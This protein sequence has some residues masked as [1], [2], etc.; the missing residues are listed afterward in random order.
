MDFSRIKITGKWFYFFPLL[1]A[2]YPVI[3]LY[4]Q[5]VQELLFPQ[6][7]VPVAVALSATILWWACL[8]FFMKDALKAGVI[9]TV[10]IIFFTM[11]GTL[12][13]WLVSWDL[14]TVKHRHILP[15][16]LFI[17]AYL[18]YFIYR[19]K[20]REL[21]VNAAKVLTILVAVL[22]V[23]NIINI[24][25]YELKKIEYAHQKPLMA[26]TPLS[27]N[28]T[29]VNQSAGYPD[30]YYFVFDEYAS[31]D[32][33]KEIWGYDNSEFENFLK[34][35]G[36]YIAEKSKTRKAES[37]YSMASSLNMEHLDPGT[38]ELS[39]FSQLNNNKVMNSL[40]NKGYTL[41]VFDGIKVF[42]PNK[43]NITA[44]YEYVYNTGMENQNFFINDRSDFENI[45]IEKTMLSSISF[46]FG[47]WN[48]VNDR[49]WNQMTFVFQNMKS[50]QNL[51][52]PK[53][54]YIH[55]NSPHTPFVFDKEGNPVDRKNAHNWRDKRYYLEQLLYTN[56]QITPVIE[57]ILSSE[58]NKPIIIIQ[59]DHGPRPDNSPNRNENFDI[60]LEQKQK[61]FNAYY[62]PGN[63]SGSLYQNISPV[64]SFRVMFNCYFKG[65]FTLLEDD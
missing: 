27:G 42:Y 24:I 30:I 12:F 65:N 56:T 52:S 48:N 33:L 43:G 54:V 25:P 23:L 55:V 40:K 38:D 28:L 49:Y 6:L 10:F 63:C 35:K 19:I 15:I 16:V 39:L 5:N 7:F 3:F 37:L 60:P 8:S 26:A 58:K 21:M 34:D 41:V 13:G 31:S 46:R 50:V 44:D 11:Y 22:L 64:N 9:T 53:F 57:K 14:F 2:I 51:S 59:S 4:S 20:S 18:G 61:I 17:A 47:R 1:F 62:F 45:L 29:D 36:F 32:T